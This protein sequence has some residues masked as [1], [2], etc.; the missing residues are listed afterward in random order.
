MLF[1]IHVCEGFPDIHTHTHTH[2]HTYT[3]VYMYVYLLVIYSLVRLWLRKYFYYFS[4]FWFSETVLVSIACKLE[5]NI[6]WSILSK[7]VESNGWMLGRLW[8][9]WGFPCL[10]VDRVVCHCSM[11]AVRRRR[12]PESETKDFIAHSTTNSV[13][14][15]FVSVSCVPISYRGDSQNPR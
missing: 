14:L 7:T 13:S 15:M 12:P 2:T 5:D 3:F 1:N 4:H 8:K 11:P 6:R 10:Q 9:V